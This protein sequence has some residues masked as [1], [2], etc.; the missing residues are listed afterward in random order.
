MLRILL[1]PLLLAATWNTTFGQKGLSA[2][3]ADSLLSVAADKKIGDY[4]K[5]AAIC[6][7]L[8]AFYTERKDS[9]ALTRALIYRAGSCDSQGQPDSAMALLVRAQ[10]SFA[11]ICDSVVLMT[12]D[13]Q[14]TSV[15]LSISDFDRTLS[16]ATHAIAQWN[17]KWT[18]RSI[19]YLLMTNEAIA[20]SSLKKYKDAE[21]TFRNILEEAIEHKDAENT[22]NGL[23]NLGT[24]KAMEG[25]QDSSEYFYRKALNS[26]K[27]RGAYETIF[28]L[29]INMAEAEFD[30][31]HPDM[32]LAFLDSADFL[33]R[34]HNDL[35]NQANL[36]WA[37]ATLNR[38][39]GNFKDACNEFVK[40]IDLEDSLLSV[41]KIH[42]VADV[43]EKYETE[44][45]A[46]ENQQLR[47]EN[48]AS[49]LKQERL[50]RTRNI[51]LSS[52]ILLFLTAGGVYA[53]LRQ[54]RRSRAAIQKEKDISEGLLLNILPE[55][56]ATE[57]K[58][59]GYADAKHFDEATILFSDF[60]G[61][62]QLS[63]KLTPA[64]LVAE[65]DTCFKAFDGIMGKRGIEKIKTIGD[66]YMAAGGLP[67]PKSSCPADVVI[68]ALEM[69][70]FMATYKAEREA[71]GKLYFEMRVGIHTGPVIA[72]IVGV[73]K[74]A[75]DIW[76]D[77]VN[78]ASRME[79][80]GA[81]GEVNISEGTFGKVKT[82][83]GLCFTPRGKVQAKGKGEMEM[84]FVR[85]SLDEG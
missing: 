55:E 60:K 50:K 41:E 32:G 38:R 66:A 78:I 82:E 11:P 28:H 67:D 51:Y 6:D 40:Y 44:K 81:V 45:K 74:F 5:L 84:F 63:E 30:R 56:V 58:Q 53:R 48:L 73:K 25:D 4:T 76:G 49:Q 15:Y 19:R 77:T 13:L 12:I 65:I 64:E 75:Y 1:I 22:E 47:A 37:R 69:Q 21:R 62:T 46:R 29:Y 80:S 43:R 70:E 27:A 33:A 59:K 3:Q 9:C 2:H 24:L 79:S 42:A 31:Q 83:P 68:A 52:G 57:L 72:G 16:T 34:T 26:S 10:R 23:I 8:I 20:L 71:A 54:T 61:F 85:R 35:Q 7:Q 17:D 18:D 14:L 36:Q 39:T